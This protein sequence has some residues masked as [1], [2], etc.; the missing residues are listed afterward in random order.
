M[1]FIT[2][3]FG[4]VFYEH[5]APIVP[6]GVALHPFNPS[7]LLLWGVQQDCVTPVDSTCLAEVGLR[8]LSSVLVCDAPLVG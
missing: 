2:D 8:P 7:W 6:M 3:D 1:M 5:K 4:A